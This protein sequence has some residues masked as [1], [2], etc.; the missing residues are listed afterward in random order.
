MTGLGLGEVPLHARIS[1]P[2]A[3]PVEPF[4]FAM[5]ETGVQSTASLRGEGDIDRLFQMLPIDAFLLSGHTDVNLAIGGT[6][7]QPAVDG[8]VAL[9]R[10]SL[11][12]FETGTVLRPLD[13]TVTVAQSR[14]RLTSLHAGDGG[15][16]RLTGG[17]ACFRSGRSA[18]EWRAASSCKSFAALRRDEV[19]RSSAALSRPMA[20]SASGY[21]SRV[22]SRTTE[23]KSG[24]TTVCSQSIAHRGCRVQG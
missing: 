16:G 8:E 18:A 23:R 12:V 5:A 2:V 3:S 1:A 11:E 6:I 13:L 17:A 7:Q 10:G 24:W 4:V 14:W 21:K 9:A 20:R 22:V 15:N 19:Y